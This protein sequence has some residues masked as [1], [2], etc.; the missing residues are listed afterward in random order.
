M[1]SLDLTTF[2]DRV[3]DR[4]FYDQYEFGYNFA[5]RGA[6]CLHTL[7]HD[8]VSTA[9]GATNTL[10]LK[11][12]WSNP[13][14]II[15]DNWV[16][17]L[18]DM[19]DVLAAF[20]EPHKRIFYSDWMYVYTNSLADLDRLVAAQPDG[21]GTRARVALPRDVVILEKPQ[22]RYRSYFRGRMLEQEQ[23]HALRRFLLN[24]GDCYRLTPGFRE[25]LAASRHV[26]VQSH[27][28]IDH[29]DVRDIQMLNLVSPGIIRKTL[30]IQA[31]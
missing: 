26:Y 2:E 1:A 4:L 12:S 28:F 5:M 11:Y 25:R 21:N 7:T 8:A 14:R 13:A 17:R 10:L 24:R 29:D 6:R 27:F 19:C 3:R 15:D 18:H 22:H 23:G 9:V 16:A 30:P 31:K 20:E